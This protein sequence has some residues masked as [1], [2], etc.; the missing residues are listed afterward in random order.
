MLFLQRQLRVAN[1]KAFVEFLHKP[2]AKASGPD[3]SPWKGQR[4]AGLWWETGATGRRGAPVR[5]DEPACHAV[6]AGM[7]RLF[8]FG[9]M[10]RGRPRS[11]LT[12]RTTRNR[13]AKAR[14]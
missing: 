14:S 7:I 10:M 4:P 5:A 9:V 1:V 13:R 11:A 8:T 2:L 6:S 12:V 3:A